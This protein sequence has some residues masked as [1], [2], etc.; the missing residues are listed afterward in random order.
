MA[1]RPDRKLGL[2]AAFATALTLTT[3]F[4]SIAQTAEQWTDRIQTLLSE[5]DHER[6]E[7]LINQFIQHHPGHAEAYVFR[8]QVF[9]GRQEIPKALTDL[10]IAIGLEPENA[11]FLFRR[12]LLAY[13]CGR[14]DLAR[15]DFRSILRLRTPVTQSV[16]YRQNN[17]GGTDR[18][19]TLASPIADQILHY[20]ALTEIKSARY[21]R[22]T[23]LLDSAILLNA[24]DADL[25]AHRGLAR[26]KSGDLG[27]AESDYQRAFDLEPDHTLILQQR[28][29]H[30][31]WEGH[32]EEAE[33]ALS[34][35]IDAQPK[36][37]EAY[38]QRGFIRFRQSRFE[39]ALADYDSAL[40]L[41]P[42]DAEAWLNR[43]LVLEKLSKPDQAVQDYETAL[44]I[45]ERS[46]RAWLMLANLHYRMGRFDESIEQF[47]VHLMLNPESASGHF[48]RAMALHRK[49]RSS[50]ACS[51]LVQAERL[52]MKVDASIRKRICR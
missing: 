20:L 48:N 33:V 23:E 37:A 28:A 16:F 50:E 51:D 24:T 41:D 8:S 36:N 31:Q 43:G 6:A 47:T 45:D 25:Y 38:G 34:Q 10:S 5:K 44:R 18:I 3:C 15:S 19:I 14:L 22:A 39:E 27:G 9:E 21:Q 4:L 13:Q 29:A 32:E 26:E 1:L 49:K 12:G 35:A 40:R 7:R 42:L 46:Q 52:G 17:R 11:E 30:A 2:R